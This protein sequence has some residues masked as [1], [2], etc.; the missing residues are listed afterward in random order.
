VIDSGPGTSDGLD[1]R[2]WDIGNGRIDVTVPSGGSSP[3][4]VLTAGGQSIASSPNG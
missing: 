3:V 2:S 1:V 4:T